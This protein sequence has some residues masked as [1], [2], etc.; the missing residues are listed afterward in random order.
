MRARP[1]LPS[2]IAAVSHSNRAFSV[3]HVN[4][5][6]MDQKSTH[7]GD[8]R[9]AP[10]HYF[11]S[12]LRSNSFLH[13]G[14]KWKGPVQLYETGPN[15]KTSS[16][17]GQPAGPTLVKERFKKR[18]A[19]HNLKASVMS[20]APPR[21]DAKRL[22]RWCC[23]CRAVVGS[24]R[25]TKCLWCGDSCRRVAAL[26]WHSSSES[27]RHHRD[28]STSTFDCVDRAFKFPIRF[29]VDDGRCNPFDGH[30]YFFVI[31]ISRR[32]IWHGGR[33]TRLSLA[34]TRCDARSR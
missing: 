24:D 26:H 33:I 16:H 8:D 25:Q 27:K 32:R 7:Y 19:H 23:G 30:C 12:N 3:R 4:Y 29:V 14:A 2:G 18:R 22:P 20:T 17:E 6:L 1:A 11:W 10:P 34:K 28:G 9:L 31:R 13:G 15:T 21:A 5:L